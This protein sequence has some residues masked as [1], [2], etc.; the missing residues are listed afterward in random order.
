MST[1][2]TPEKK[3]GKRKPPPEKRNSVLEK[4]DVVYVAVNAVR[5]NSYNPNRQSE[6]DFQLLCKS[7]GED[8]FTQPIIV[9]KST[10]EIVDGEHRWRACKALGFEEVPVV[11]VDM[12]PEQMRIST[13]RHNR[14]RG[15]ED[16]GLAADV[17]KDLAASGA[18]DWAK[19]S[20]QLDAE[21]VAKLMEDMPLDEVANMQVDV[22]IGML[23]PN[24]HGLSKQDGTTAVDT[25]SDER[26]A[27]E[28][29]LNDAKKGEE[30]KM[31]AADTKIYR[32]VLYYFG[33]ESLPVG[34]ALAGHPGGDAA[35]ILELCQEY[36]ASSS[37]RSTQL[38]P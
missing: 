27:K 28:R 22:P 12:S 20:L 2:A 18:L 14:A 1:E 11:F 35:A 30:E 16:A 4:L 17:L 23:G 3:K 7:I 10:M 38:H 9:L 13:L 19:D 37:Q 21:D 25:T 31:A 34:K 5:Q 8:G 32:V 26:R 24:G 29:I 36:L 15:S 6:H 33:E